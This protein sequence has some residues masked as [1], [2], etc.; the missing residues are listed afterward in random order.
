MQASV[1]QLLHPELLNTLPT[2]PHTAAPCLPFQSRSSPCCQ[3][4]GHPAGKCFGVED[5]SGLYG[6]GA[7]AFK[8]SNTRESEG[9]R[10]SGLLAVCKFY[11]K[12]GFNILMRR[13]KH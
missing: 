6:Y 4:L 7:Q 9:L 11:A 12:F 2:V 5:S 1:D 13:L 8:G 10:V 3:T